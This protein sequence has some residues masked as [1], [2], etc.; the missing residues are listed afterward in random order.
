MFERRGLGGGL[1]ALVSLVAVLAVAPTPPAGAAGCEKNWANPGTSGVWDQ[2]GVADGGE[3]QWSPAGVPAA[4]DIVCLPAGDYTVTLSPTDD[5]AYEVESLVVDGRA[6]R[7][8]TFVME[9]DV[10][11]TG[12]R[13]REHL[14]GRGDRTGPPGSSR[15]RSPRRMG[16]SC[17][18]GIVV[19]DY[20]ISDGFLHGNLGIITGDLLNT[21]SGVVDPGAPPLASSV[22]FLSV[23]GTF[24]QDTVAILHID[25][26][27]PT[28]GEGTGYDHVHVTGQTTSAA[29]SASTSP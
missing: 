7:P 26:D 25:Y 2:D 8:P 5:T 13:H 9:G 16:S 22:G 10:D 3:T 20:T 19:G 21:G 11:L 15:R 28:G 12:Q 1:L 4:G 29:R 6:D 14:R 27:T 24:T 23:G 18:T 17:S